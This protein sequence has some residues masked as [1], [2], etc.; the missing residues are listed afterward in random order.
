[1]KKS[2]GNTAKILAVAIAMT[3]SATVSAQ[4]AGTWGVKFGINKLT[5]KVE[6]GD[7][8]PPAL[9]GTKAAVGS[10]T[11]AIF[12]ASYMFT[13][14]ISVEAFGG[15]PY[16][17]DLIGDGAVKGAGKIGSAQVLPPTIFAQYRFLEAKSRFRP[18]IGLGL[19]YGYFQK[20]TGSGQLTALANTGSPTPTTFK[21]D[22]KFGLT[23]Q[24]GVTVAINDQ[25]F[26]DFAVTKT[27][28][29]T[30]AHFSTGQTQDI[31]FDPV[32]LSISVGYHF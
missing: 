10:D 24:I 18:Y 23:P 5:P 14:H 11:E 25:W 22:N 20:E 32:G 31:R 28:L 8:T 6:S 12:S 4:S 17:H 30:T 3:A 1:M 13:D 9:P 29:K 27:Y 2:F 16:T 15:L 26:A 19:S 7:L 21:L